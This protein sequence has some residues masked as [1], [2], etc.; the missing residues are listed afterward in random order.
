M[1]LILFFIPSH[2]SPSQL[3]ADHPSLLVLARVVGR[4][5]AAAGGAPVYTAAVGLDREMRDSIA[6]ASQQVQ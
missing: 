4:L 5:M 1:R 3:P 6:L 2:E